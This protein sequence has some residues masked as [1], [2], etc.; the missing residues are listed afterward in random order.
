MANI[1]LQE[2]SLGHPVNCPFAGR[3]QATQIDT[4]GKFGTVC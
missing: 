3:E 2:T 1:V 4:A